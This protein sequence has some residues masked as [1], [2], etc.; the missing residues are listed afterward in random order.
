MYDYYNIHRMVSIY[1]Q[2][3]HIHDMFQTIFKYISFYHH[4]EY[5]FDVIIPNL[6]ICTLS[7]ESIHGELTKTGTLL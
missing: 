5:L 2:N 4:F 3:H 1:H 6:L 7:V